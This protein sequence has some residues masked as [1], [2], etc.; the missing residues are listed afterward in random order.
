MQKL[1][2]VVGLAFLLALFGVIWYKLVRET[3]EQQAARWNL[4]TLDEIVAAHEK[5][6]STP[7]D[8]PLDDKPFRDFAADLRKIDL[9]SAS[10]EV[11][12]V[13]ARFAKF[14]AEA[15]EVLKKFKTGPDDAPEG[16]KALQDRAAAD[17]GLNLQNMAIQLEVL[18]RGVDDE[19]GRLRGKYRRELKR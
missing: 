11:K 4:E 19:I 18:L 13:H 1:A 14:A 10:N 3:P 9:A 2:I 12:A 5:Y 15:P 8:G 16:N 17:W 6:E 7:R